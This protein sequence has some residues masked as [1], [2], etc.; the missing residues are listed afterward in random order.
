MSRQHH[1]SQHFSCVVFYLLTAIGYWSSN[2]KCAT[3]WR[4]EG[5]E[6]IAVFGEE[7]TV[8][9]KDPLF[10]IL[11]DRKPTTTTPLQEHNK[12]LKNVSVD[13]PLTTVPGTGPGMSPPASSGRTAGEDPLATTP[14]TLSAGPASKKFKAASLTCG[15]PVN[16]TTIDHLEGILD[17][18]K[19]PP[20]PEP[21]VAL[22][23]RKNEFDNVQADVIEVNLLD[24]IQS[25]ENKLVLYN[26]IGN[27][28]RIKGDTYHA[29]ECFRRALTISHNNPDVLLNLARMLL[30][31]NY[32]KDAI[33][34]AERSLDH[35][36]PEQSTWLQ[37][38]TLAEILEKTGEFERARNHL[39]LA[40]DENPSFHPAHQIFQRLRKTPLPLG[41][42]CYTFLFIMVLCTCILMY[43]YVTIIKEPGSDNNNNNNGCHGNHLIGNHHGNGCHGSGGNGNGG[44]HSN[45]RNKWSS[46]FKRAKALS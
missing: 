8:R 4:F 41:N 38:F 2:S 6:V 26:Q 11:T 3:H 30:N 1:F 22:L 28:L 9:S 34:L 43:I 24:A 46:F 13:V 36:H 44:H 42:A 27:F 35:E 5:G 33:Y 39:Q 17:R 32:M 19:H 15:E 16:E 18:L 25:G 29:M 40:L 21:D 45:G 14:T 7:E 20:F 12:P 31:L 23:F 37:H 10:Q